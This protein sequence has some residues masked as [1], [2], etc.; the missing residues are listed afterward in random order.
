MYPNDIPRRFHDTKL[1]DRQIQGTITI[2]IESDDKDFVQFLLNSLYLD[3]L[4]KDYDMNYLM[5]DQK[6]FLDKRKIY[7]KKKNYLSIEK[8]GSLVSNTASDEMD[9]GVPAS[10]S[11][12]ISE[13]SKG[14]TPPSSSS[15]TPTLQVE[16]PRFPET[17]SQ[18]PD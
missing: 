10:L 18:V 9:D 6:M 3:L 5:L 2:S 11:E 15:K 4:P 14:G 16:K 17:V 7:I 1:K 12:G 8:N 13:E